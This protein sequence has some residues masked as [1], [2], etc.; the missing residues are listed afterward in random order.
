M[1]KAPKKPDAKKSKD[2]K[3]KTVSAEKQQNTTY[4][5]IVPGKFNENDW[6]NLL[7]IDESQEYIWELL[8]ECI[9]NANKIIYSNYLDQQTI[10]FTINEAKKAILHLIDWQFLD[11]DTDDDLTEDW[12]QDAEPEACMIDSWAQGYV[13]TVVLEN[14]E[15]QKD[16]IEKEDEQKSS[17][18]FLEE[19][20]QTPKNA[21]L[22]ESIPIDSSSQT[23]KDQAGN[24]RTNSG[25]KSK[26]VGIS[27]VVNSYS[28]RKKFIPKK[29]FSESISVNQ[30]I[31]SS[32][33]PDHSMF[34]FEEKVSEKKELPV[35]S[36]FKQID[37]EVKKM[38]DSIVKA[39]NAAQSLL[40]TL[41]TRP[42]GQREIEIDPFGDV[43]SIAKLDF[44]KTHHVGIKTRFKLNEGPKADYKDLHSRRSRLDREDKDGKTNKISY[45]SS[46]SFDRSL[47]S[48]KNLQKSPRRNKPK[49]TQIQEDD[50]ELILDPV[51]GVVFTMLN[52]VRVGPKKALVPNRQQTLYDKS[53]IFLKPIKPLER[54]DSLT[55]M[56]L[57]EILESNHEISSIKKQSQFKPMPPISQSIQQH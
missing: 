27:G 53:E 23:V 39:P 13:Q 42:V 6:N 41:L 44:D 47:D 25:N 22:V 1:S 20:T 51:P 33:K 48:R 3:G 43:T 52:S 54:S 50:G 19:L 45:N 10:P 21:Q 57:E 31:P 55:R 49:V 11:D 9:E 34:S 24:S 15:F 35:H 32:S 29:K 4:L 37:A 30:A 12:N 17:G 46:N 40:K 8:D 14:P 36:K 28:I 26:K 2:V 16:I 18:S 56:S 38:Q 7:D 5:D